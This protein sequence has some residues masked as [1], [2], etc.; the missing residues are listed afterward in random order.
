MRINLMTIQSIRWALACTLAMAATLLTACGTDNPEK[1]LAS[2]K[3]YLAKGEVRAALIELKTALQKKPDSPEARFLLGKALL[4]GDEPVGA[5]VELRKALELKH[6]RE[7]VLPELAR[8]MLELGQH[9]EIVA[10]FKDTTLDDKTALASLRTSLGWAYARSAQVPQ[11]EASFKQALD[12]A[13]GYVPAQ[14]AAARLL[15]IR[16]DR[17]AAMKV[18]E[19]IIAA[20]TADTDTWVLQGDLLAFDKNDRSGTIAAYRKAIALSKAHLAAHAGIIIAQLSGGDVK[21]AGDQ[22]SEL[23]KV[24]PGHPMTRFFQAQV[25]YE[26]GDFKAA[27]ELVQQLLK[28]APDNPQVNQLAGAIELASGSVPLARTYLSKTLQARPDSAIARRLLVMAHLKS[29]EASKALE[30]LEPLLAVN[31]PDGPALALA[32]EA[33]MQAGELDKAGAMFSRA[34]QANPKDTTSLTALARTRFLKG[35]PIGA[36]ADLQQIA[37]AD[38]GTVADLELVNSQLR[39]RDFPA[40]LTAIESLEGKLP[41]KPST[42]L[43]RG[44]AYLGLRDATQAR[45]SFEKALTLD[46]AFFPAVFSLATLDIADKKPQVAQQRIEALLKTQPGHLQALLALADL[47][48]RSGAS[49]QEVTDL[50]ATAARLNPTQAPAHLSLINNHL[51]NKQADLALAAAQ[52]ADA[53]L[54]AHPAILDALGRAQTAAGQHIQALAT[55]NKI[56]ALQPGNAVALMHIADVQLAMKDSAA[57]IQSLKRAVAANPNSAAVLQRLFVLELQAGRLAEAL[58][59]ARDLQKRLPAHSAG[60]V[61]EGDAQRALK[62]NETALAAYKLALDK[63]PPSG[64]PAR[65]HS[66]LLAAGKQA[67]ADQFATSWAKDH[68]NDIAFAVYR[69]DTALARRDLV[70]AEAAYRHVIELQPDHVASLNNIAWLM[71]KA[72]KPGALAFAEKANALQ[73]NQPALMDTL[74]IVLAAEKRFDRAI[75]VQKKALALAPDSNT[76]RL[77]LARIYFQAGDKTQARELLEPLSKLGEKFAGQAEV[78]SLLVA[79]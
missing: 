77:G 9:K 40:A 1:L 41:N 7:A 21:A 58:K 55:F 31:S 35:D 66:L 5:E 76:M 19:G 18:V 17:G 34:A 53:A 15:A 38:T 62:A 32:G 45:A 13:P 67:E 14:V 70:G 56:L 23:Q 63:A 39:R 28:G 52:Q 44:A 22:V 4:A 75:D 51:V 48:A 46:P 25:A 79:L 2:A 37:A 49:K 27:K 74:A 8:A 47:R 43:L 69:G 64:A 68:A 65:V 72:N 60:Y 57:A 78:R 12:T 16:G 24:R 3:A 10:Q 50:L 61:L 71:V 73:P 36:V 30:L 59:L 11:A 54:P 20:G 6:P 29:G 26:K 33:Y 42:S